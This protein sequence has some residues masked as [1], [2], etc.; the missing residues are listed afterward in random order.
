MFGFGKREMPEPP[1][2]ES[3]YVCETGLLRSDNQD[4]VFLSAERGIFCVADGVGGGA[5]GAKASAT[6]CHELNLMT[7]GLGDDFA[8][9]V[10]AMRVGLVDANAVIYAYAREHGFEVMGSTAAV[11]L[12]D[13]ED[14]SR[15]AVVHVGDSRVYRVRHGLYECITH[16]HR[17]Y[18]GNSLTR[19]IGAR[20]TL[21]CDVDEIGVARGDRFLVCTDGVTSVVSD[22]RIAAFVGA[23]PIESA[24]ERLAAEVVKCGA[25]DNY[26]FIVISA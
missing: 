17:I 15:A 22:G 8:Q 25:P 18:G 24:A 21:A 19:A 9:R 5:E 7:R 16:D 4:N 23:G 26:S 1:H 12:F 13:P 10:Q 6:V 20:P 14:G 11:L 2:L 3:V